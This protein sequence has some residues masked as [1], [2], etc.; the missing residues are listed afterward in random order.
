MKIVKWKRWE[1]WGEGV[2]VKTAVGVREMKCPYC[3]SVR[4][5]RHGVCVSQ[6][7]CSIAGAM[8]GELILSF[9]I[10]AGD[11]AL[12]GI[13]S[14]KITNYYSLT[15]DLPDKQSKRHHG[16]SKTEVLAR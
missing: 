2:I 10:I 4:L 14:M 7:R 8:A 16:N 15:P 5:Y 9:T 13:L 1:R 12:V 6:G 3:D 11:A